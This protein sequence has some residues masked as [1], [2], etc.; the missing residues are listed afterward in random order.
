M[1]PQHLAVSASQAAEATSHTM[2]GSPGVTWP[3][4]GHWGPL[5]MSLLPSGQLTAGSRAAAGQR[6]LSCWPHWT[7]T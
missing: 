5:Q 4:V 7:H 6:G 3:W 1:V 2:K